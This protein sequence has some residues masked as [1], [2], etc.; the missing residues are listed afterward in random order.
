VIRRE[1]FVSVGQLAQGAGVSLATARRD[2]R[3][4]AREGLVEALHGGAR[5]LARHDSSRADSSVA[6]KSL[7]ESEV[8]SGMTIGLAGGGA[9]D[10][11]ATAV[12]A[13]TGV[14]VVTNS[15]LAWAQLGFNGSDDTSR[16]EPH[17]VAG[18]LADGGVMTG[19]LAIASIRLFR[20]DV[21]LLCGGAF[22]A[23]TGFT[24]RSPGEAEIDREFA[25]NASKVVIVVDNAEP[26]AGFP[27]I[28]CGPNEITAVI[29]LS[30]IGQYVKTNHLVV[31]SQSA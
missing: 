3:V 26:S 19:S 14:K 23:D 21:V 11:V 29:R 24:T 8:R 16:P 18:Q 28:V 22:D 13:I 4:L 25:R 6:L 7:V 30:A 9:I 20:F 31:R 10:R 1:G 17:F 2:I 27:A 15:L 5:R 12:A